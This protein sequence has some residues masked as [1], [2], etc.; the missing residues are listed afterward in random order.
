LF[1]FVFGHNTI[2]DGTFAEKLGH[3]T[4]D[5]I[6]GISENS[7]S[8]LFQGLFVA[9]NGIDLVKDILKLGIRVVDKILRS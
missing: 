8:D 7:V 1:E 2:S 4:V 6:T 3:D 9:K 5:G